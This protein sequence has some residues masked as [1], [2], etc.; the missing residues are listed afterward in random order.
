M[1]GREEDRQEEA[2]V[3]TKEEQHRVNDGWQCPECSGVRTRIGGPPHDRHYE[4]AEC[5]C[6]WDNHYYPKEQAL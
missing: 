5:G 3:I 6:F 2:N 1:C 4:C